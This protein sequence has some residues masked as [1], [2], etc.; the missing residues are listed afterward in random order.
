VKTG[1][2]LVESSN[3]DYVSKRALA[4]D[5]DDYYFW[6]KGKGKIVPVLN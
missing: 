1:C 5:D 2:D 4:N 6:S 3:E